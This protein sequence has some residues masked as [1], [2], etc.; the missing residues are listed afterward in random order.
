MSPDITTLLVL[1]TALSIGYLCSRIII[2]VVL[3][4]SRDDDELVDRLTSL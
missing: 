2:W 3:R 1:F 4:P